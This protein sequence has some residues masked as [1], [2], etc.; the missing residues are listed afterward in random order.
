LGFVCFAAGHVKGVGVSHTAS[1]AISDQGINPVG[2]TFCQDANMDG[3]C[4]GEGE[5]YKPFC[6]SVVL[7]GSVE[8]NEALA[9]QVFVDGPLNG[10]PVIS[11]CG[12]GSTSLGT[13]GFVTHS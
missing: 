13:L 8:W 6:V 11:S 1:L 3:F 9:V 4:G 5:P 12:L 10:N 7:V 2:G